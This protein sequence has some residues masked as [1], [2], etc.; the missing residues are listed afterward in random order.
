[1]R[2]A[3]HAIMQNKILVTGG[4]GFIGTNFILH[5]MSQASSGIVNLES[6][7]TPA[8]RTTCVRSRK[9]PAMSLCTEISATGDSY[10]ICSSGPGHKLSFISQPRVMLTDRFTVQTTSFTPT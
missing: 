9:A 7:P 5:W 4:A 3:F 8:I 2:G 6:L 1:M 10:E